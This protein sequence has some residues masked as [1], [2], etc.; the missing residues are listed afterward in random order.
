MSGSYTVHR[1][2]MITIDGVIQPG[3][4]EVRVYQN[5]SVEVLFDAPRQ[6]RP[7]LYHEIHVTIAYYQGDGWNFDS[8]GEFAKTRGWHIGDLLMVNGVRST[9]DYFF[10]TRA[11]SYDEALAK[12]STFI[13]DL[14]RV[15]FKVIRFKIEDTV[16]DSREPDSVPEALR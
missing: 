6:P 4:G 2:Q 9:K 5:G 7:S 14:A 12:M 8:L 11:P 15:G 3:N 13:A 10:T 16:L 1:N